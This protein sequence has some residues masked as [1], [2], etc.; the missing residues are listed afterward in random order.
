MK[1]SIIA[2]L[3]SVLSLT[4][5]NFV[6]FHPNRIVAGKPFSIFESAGFAGAIPLILMLATI[7]YAALSK[8]RGKWRWYVLGALPSIATALLFFTAG[9]A[10]TR[11]SLEA[12]PIVRVSL[13]GGFWIPLLL[14]PVI[15]IDAIQ[16]MGDWKL[17]S[18]AGLLSA[19]FVAILFA[20]GFM[21]D[22]SLM[23]E[24]ANRADRFIAELITHLALSSTAVTLAVLIGAP[25]GLLAQRRERLSGPT[26]FTLNVLQTIPSLALFSILIPLIAALTVLFPAL[27][28]A[29]IGAIGSTPALIALTIYSILPVARNTYTGLRAVDSA[30]VEAARGMGMTPGQRLIKVE[31]PIAS[32][33]ILGGVRIA[34]VQAVGL[35][36]VAALIGAG[37][38]GTFIFLG[39][40]Q[41][42]DDLILLGALPTVL[43]ALAADGA[44][45]GL[46]KIVKPKGI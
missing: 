8:S 3:G 30:M 42:A 11:L 40:G 36:A 23:K 16:N 19:I 2:A 12:S 43:V 6:T 26:F 28:N 5:A 24:Y 35:T 1:V 18:A 25:L 10:A 27:K 37:G 21:D 34:L 4:L 38:L 32:P 39:I 46:I 15:L 45:Q 7:L 22:L 33:I 44:M 9:Q 20:S 41:S 29:G 31:L 17:P 14:L 13:G